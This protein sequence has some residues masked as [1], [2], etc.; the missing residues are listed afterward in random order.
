MELHI[1]IAF[2]S[3]LSPEEVVEAI[4]QLIPYSEF[5]RALYALTVAK[6]VFSQRYVHIT[7]IEVT[8]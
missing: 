8:Q 2:T 4:I 7:P 1:N 3:V 5:P 6:K